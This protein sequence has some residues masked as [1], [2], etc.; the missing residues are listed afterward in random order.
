V[1]TADQQKTFDH[2][3]H[4]MKEEMDRRNGSS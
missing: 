1:L 2:N 3:L 4:E